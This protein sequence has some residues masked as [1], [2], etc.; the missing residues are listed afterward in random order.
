MQIRPRFPDRVPQRPG[1][2]TSLEAAGNWAI[3]HPKGQLVMAG[4]MIAPDGRTRRAQV[5]EGHGGRMAPA[6]SAPVLDSFLQPTH[7]ATTLTMFDSARCFLPALATSAE[8]AD[9]ELHACNPPPPPSVA[10]PTRVEA[11]GAP[12]PRAL[13]LG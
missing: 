6:A 4:H 10:P 1:R 2:I 7:S 13:V 9:P 8:V 12:P 11:I 3:W 5:P